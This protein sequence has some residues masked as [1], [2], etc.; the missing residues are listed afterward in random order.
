LGVEE[1]ESED[2]AKVQVPQTDILSQPFLFLLTRPIT[3]L[4]ALPFLHVVQTSIN[5]LPSCLHI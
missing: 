2:T 5:K 1:K 3:R 4:Y